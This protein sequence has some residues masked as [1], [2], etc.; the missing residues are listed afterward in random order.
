MT[1][2]KTTE[3]PRA[4]R[5]GGFRHAAQ[6]A[7]KA[8]TRIAGKKGFAEADVLL[9]WVEIAGASTS[10]IC[11]PVRVQ[12]GANR[13]LGAVL[14]VEAAGGRSP[15]ISHQAPRIVERVNQF[16]G[17]RAISRLKIEQKAPAGPRGFAEPSAAFKGHAQTRREAGIAPSAA[18][19]AG[20]ADLVK[21]VQSEALRDA[22]ATMGAHVLARSR[23]GSSEN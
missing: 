18:D 8:M 14:V 17:Y 7:R 12:Y 9:R 16:Y 21:S 6:T 23:T 4:R 22:L 13:S 1:D 11:R 2:R 19:R 10:E 15:E 5:G 3:G 20:A